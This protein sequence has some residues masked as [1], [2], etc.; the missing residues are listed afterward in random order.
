MGTQSEKVREN[1]NRRWAKRLGLS[2]KKSRARHFSV[3]NWGG[4]MLIDQNKN[5]IYYGEKFDLD[6]GQVEKLLKKR[7]HDLRA[8]ADGFTRDR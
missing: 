4:Y 7:D 2:L 3:D 5:I 8:D 1:Y 6:L